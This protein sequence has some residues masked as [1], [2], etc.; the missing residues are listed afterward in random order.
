MLRILYSDE[1]LPNTIYSIRSFFSEYYEPEWIDSEFGRAAIK[2]ID[3]SDVVTGQI[4][5]SPY[6][7]VIPPEKL[8]GGVKRVLFL[9]FEG[10]AERVMDITGCGDNCAKWIQRVGAEKDIDVQLN[11]PMTFH[12]TEHFPIYIKNLDRLCY[13]DDEVL[14]AYG[15]YLC[16]EDSD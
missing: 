14:S 1:R 10:T 12:D 9:K 5:S 11:Y 6:L 16:M 7:G 2:D 13:N 15:E 4:I 3:K 8:S